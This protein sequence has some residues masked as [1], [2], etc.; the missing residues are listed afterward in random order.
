MIRHGDR[1]PMGRAVASLRALLALILLALETPGFADVLRV[2]TFNVE[3]ARKGPGLLLRDLTRGKDPQIDAIV[4]VIARHSPDV[5]AIQNFDWDHDQVALAAF[6]E[7]LADAGAPYPHRFSAR[8]NSGLATDLDL[9][10]DRRL[11]GPGDAQGFGAFTGQGGLAVLSRHPIAV[12]QVT[13]LSDLLWKDLPDAL[14]PT[15]A[16][17]RPFPSDDAIAIQLLSS[18]AHWIVP[19]ALPDGGLFDLLTFQAGPPVFDGAEDRNGR[20]NHDEIRLWTEVLDGRFGSLH[21]RFVLAGGANLD[22]HDSDGRFAAMRNLLADSRLQDP[23]P[24]SAGAA[25]SADQGHTGDNALDTVD[26]DGVGRMRV[27]Y[28]LPASGWK[29]IDAGVAWPAEGEDGRAEALAASRHR[30]VWVDLALD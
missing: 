22:P 19:I 10:G 12:A 26:W 1:M 23:R 3:L 2:G 6:A 18:T 15:W 27:D 21:D 9:D 11:G 8:P 29:V 28:V 24:A 16:D 17:G 7:R 4:A 5:L 14:L 20:R 30:L 25:R 13:D